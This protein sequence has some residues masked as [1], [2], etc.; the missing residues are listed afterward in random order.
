M[1][2][3]IV[4]IAAALSACSS[5]S[6]VDSVDARRLDWGGGNLIDVVKDPQTGTVCY[7]FSRG[8]LQCALEK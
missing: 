4:V 1:K 5:V 3:V 6:R 2:L 8:G 7:A